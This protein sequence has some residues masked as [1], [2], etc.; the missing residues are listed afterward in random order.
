MRERKAQVDQNGEARRTGRDSRRGMGR[1]ARLV[2]FWE[3]EMLWL[4][5]YDFEYD[6]ARAEKCDISVSDTDDC[7]GGSGGDDVEYDTVRGWIITCRMPADRTVGRRART[8]AM[9]RCG[10]VQ[11][12]ERKLNG[13]SRWPQLWRKLLIRCPL[14]AHLSASAIHCRLGS[15][16]LRPIRQKPPANIEK[17]VNSSVCLDVL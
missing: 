9:L 3:R 10:A 1:A 4:N 2:S 5:E 6:E 15:A 7:G 14:N 17:L 13:M 12:E 11:E 8:V 16:Y